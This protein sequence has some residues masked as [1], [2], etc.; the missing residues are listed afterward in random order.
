MVGSNRHP[1][2]I[3]DGPLVPAAELEVGRVSSVSLNEQSLAGLTEEQKARIEG[4]GETVKVSGP[5]SEAKRLL[6]EILRGAISVTESSTGSSGAADTRAN[7]EGQADP[8]D[9]SQDDSS[10]QELIGAQPTTT[11]STRSKS[12]EAE[13]EEEGGTATSK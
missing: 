3:S 7:T 2:Q 4:L 1:I 5:K 11:C 6:Q 10:A 9:T 12:Q 8:D 13:G